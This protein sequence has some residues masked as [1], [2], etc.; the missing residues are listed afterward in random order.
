MISGMKIIQFL[1]ASGGV[2][3]SSYLVTGNSNQTILID[4]GLFQGTD[5][6]ENI[7]TKPISFDAQNLSAAFV[8][9]AHL[10]H[11]GRL[12]LLIQNGFTGKIY[13][14][15]PT[16]E[17]IYLSLMDEVAIAQEE[18]KQPLFSKEDVE[19]TMK[20][21][22][23]VAYDEQ[24]TVGEFSITF[25]NAGHI[26]GS[27]SIEITNNG[28]TIC[29]SGDLGNTPQDLI[30]PT[31][32]ITSANFVV[33]ESTYGNSTHPEE[34][35]N[36]I[37]QKEIN[38]I[39]HA[40]GTLLIPAFSIERT[41]EI[42]HRLNHLKKTNKILQETPV[43]LDS[44]LAIEVT[45]IFKQNPA[46]YNTDLQKDENPFDFPNLIKTKTGEESKQ[47]LKVESPKII[48]A[49]SGMM[50]GGRILHHLINY[51]PLP[52]TKIIIVGYQAEKTLGREILEGVKN[53]KIYHEEVPVRAQVTHIFSLSSHADQPKLLEWLKHIK[54]VEKVFLT[55][56]DNPQREE[57]QNQIKKQ[58]QIT[59]VT[60]PLIGERYEIN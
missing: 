46:F 25:R 49:G 4:L 45:D 43:F 18:K 53:V 31:E 55:H 42:L 32:Y 56:G 54:N 60:L 29:F 41:Q 47:I 38:S 20:L 2:T 37:L 50:S 27:S 44:P 58:T 52:T 8:T 14:T 15:K 24:I 5:D 34:D 59:E 3:G 7:N 1:G 28:K 51:L 48:I 33:M 23:L 39:E 36:T 22:E 21:F 12:P 30:A 11:C 16:K 35:V 17:I 19:K 6:K 10:D 40:G 13:S 9:H 57:L 26:L